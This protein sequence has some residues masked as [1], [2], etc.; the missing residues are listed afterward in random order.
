[1][2]V[3]SDDEVIILE[4]DCHVEDAEPLAQLLQVP[5]RTLRFI[6]CRKL[7]TAVFQA[8]LVFKPAIEGLTGDEILDTLLARA[9]PLH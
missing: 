3:R 9:P 5:G 6:G 1:M 4:G 7:H 2:S 8:I